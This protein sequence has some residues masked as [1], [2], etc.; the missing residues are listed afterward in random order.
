MSFSPNSSTASQESEGRCAPTEPSELLVHFSDLLP[1]DGMAMDLAC[2]SARNTLCLARQGLTA[3]G[4]DRSTEALKSGREAAAR[5]NL[6]VSFV[7]ADLTRFVLPPN[8]FCAVICFNYRD[9]SLYP[10]IRASLRP[11]GLLIYETYTLEHRKCGRKPLN[12]AFL[13]ERS[14]LLGVFG[15]WEIIYYRE[16]WVGGGAASLVARKPGLNG[17]Y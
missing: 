15:D 9:R 6:N 11:G 10:S 13:L 4:V 14:E 12:S 8:A 16:V 5:L 17:K 3:I 7:Q 2:G 1:R